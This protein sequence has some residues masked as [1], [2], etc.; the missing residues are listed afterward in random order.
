MRT[1]EA[2]KKFYKTP[3]GITEAWFLHMRRE[4]LEKPQTVKN[5]AIQESMESN[6]EQHLWNQIKMDSCQTEYKKKKKKQQRKR[7]QKIKKY[8]C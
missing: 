1:S 2:L 5:P 4:L 7:F 8:Q 3:E 6:K